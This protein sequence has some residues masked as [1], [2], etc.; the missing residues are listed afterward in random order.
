[1]HHQDDRF[2]PSK[3]GRGTNA[4]PATSWRTRHAAR[5]FIS[6][7]GLVQKAMF[8][9]PSLGVSESQ[10]DPLGGGGF[11]DIGT[12]RGDAGPSALFVGTRGWEGHPNGGHKGSSHVGKIGAFPGH[13]TVV[14]KNGDFPLLCAPPSHC[15]T[16]LRSNIESDKP[17]P[18]DLPRQLWQC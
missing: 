7:V 13:R 16:L 8:C 15:C 11:C 10:P 17:P 6:T 18:V 14:L 2:H 3:C 12:A 9:N 1:M 4:T 5:R